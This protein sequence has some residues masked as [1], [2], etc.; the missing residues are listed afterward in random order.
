MRRRG[1]DARAGDELL[2]AG[3][4]VG[5]LQAAAAAAAGRRRTSSSRQT[6]RVAIVSTGSELVAAGAP[7]AA[8]PDPRVELASCS[9]GLALEAG[10]GV[11]LRRS[12]PDDARRPA[13]GRSPHADDVGADVV[14]F[15]G[16]VSAG[17]YEVVKST[18]GPGREMEFFKVAMQPGKPQGFGHVPGGALLF[19]L[20]GNPVSAAVS[21]EVFVRPALL[22]LQGRTDIHRPVLRLPGRRR[23]GARRPGRRQYLPAALDRTDPAAWTVAARDRR[24]LRLAPRGRPRPR[25]GVR[26]RPGRGRGGRGRRPR[27]CHAGLMSFTHLDDAGHARM[28]DVTDKQPTVR[29]ATARGFVRCGADVVAALRD[30][31]V[32][33]GD[34]LAV[35][36]I[37]GIQGAKKCAELL[38]LAHVIGVHGAVGRPRASRTTGVA[39]EATVRTAD[40]TGVEMEALTA[41]SVAALAIVDMVKGLDKSVEIE[42]VRLIAKEGG[43]SGVVGAAGRMTRPR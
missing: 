3:T 14:V 11:V 15:S 37:A 22:A 38:P 5:P 35:A 28:V 1:E 23:R 43:R 18:L 27:R 29:A 19:G 26:D 6:P 16:G 34:V 30:G 10:A 12:V 32:P 25:R 39:I 4:L 40:R 31:T 36:R 17:A 13:R 21:F 7:L 8:R 42:N 9:T 41:V 2:P 33:K 20:P 24:R